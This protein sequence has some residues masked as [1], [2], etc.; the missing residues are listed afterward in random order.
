MAETIQNRNVPGAIKICLIA[1]RY[2]GRK[3]SSSRLK[4]PRRA[5]EY[6]TTLT[7]LSPLWRRR[8]VRMR[9][10]FSLRDRASNVF[11]CNNMISP[12]EYPGSSLDVVGV[13]TS[14]GILLPHFL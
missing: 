3:T 4:A 13:L 8:C 7:D 9:W 11:C 2:H 6:H 5:I 12:R 14:A 1:L 10:I